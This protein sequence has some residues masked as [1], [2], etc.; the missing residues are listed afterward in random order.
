MNHLDHLLSE[1]RE[2]NR[3]VDAKDTHGRNT[4]KGVSVN[5]PHKRARPEIVRSRL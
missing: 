3:N 1:L 5:E 4:D 2:L